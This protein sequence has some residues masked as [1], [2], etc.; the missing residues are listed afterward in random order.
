MPVCITGMHRSG[1][2]LLAQ[3]L[4]STG[5]DLGPT[6]QLLP[7]SDRNADG[8]WE[9]PRFVAINDSI[10]ETLGGRWDLPPQPPPGWESGNE[11]AP[12][13]AEA[14]ALTSTIGLRSPW[15]WKD[16]RSSLTLPFWRSI[17]PGMTTIVCVRNPLEVAQS[18]V[19]RDQ[20]SYLVAMR[21]WLV[22]SERI[23]GT[24]TPQTRIVTHYDALLR[25]P[26]AELRRIVAWLGIAVDESAIQASAGIVKQGLRHNQTHTADLETIQA[27]AS[28]RERYA[29]F[30]AEAG[31]HDEAM[32]PGD[33]N[34]SVYLSAVR[35]ALE[36]DARVE[37]H[38]QRN[39]ALAAHVEHLQNRLAQRRHRYADALAR[40][41]QR[42]RARR[43]SE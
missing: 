21:L 5:L 35:V 2:S 22:Y 13:R 37:E 25:S 40:W 34:R 4:R 36:L 32:Q 6:E 39:R 27:P 10:L 30:C 29:D 41:L 9:H 42:L 16:P 12:L 23:L 18:L 26:I 43:A 33:R 8:Y 3:L 1:T 38:D 24:T 15:G 17:F 20:F 28:I 31:F 11:F 19:D 7:P 14:Q